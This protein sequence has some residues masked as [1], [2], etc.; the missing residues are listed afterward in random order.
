M[1][2]IANLTYRIAGR[3]LLDSASARIP[4]GWRVGLVGRNGTGKST[5]LELIRGALQPDGGDI[6]TRGRV[7]IV[8]QEA[9]GGEVTPIDHVL[10]ADNER[11]TLLAEA[12]AAT[13]PARLAQIHDRLTAIAAHAAP[14]RAAAILAGVGF[15]EAMQHRPLSS[16]SGGWRMRVALAAVLFAEPELLLLDEP[17][18]HLDLEAT[19]WLESYLKTYPHTLVI[20]SHDRSLLNA[21]CPT[22]SC[23]STG[24]S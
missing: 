8:V 5:L 20:V 23:T 12:E 18:N 16:Y 14:A 15:D 7:G 19:A 24:R 2:A 10:T 17:T 9:P 3:T 4:D 11:A 13:D 1:L 22:I 21:P 6:E